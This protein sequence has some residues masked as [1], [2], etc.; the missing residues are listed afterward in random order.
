M[1]SSTI[2]AMRTIFL[3]DAHLTSS[4]EKNYRHVCLFLRELIGLTETLFIMGDLFDFWLGFPSRSFIAPHE[5]VLQVLDEL[6]RSGCRLV[7][8]EGN[9]DFHLGEVFSQRLGAEIHTGPAIMNVQGKRLYLCH[10]DQLNSE[11]YGYRLL[12]TMLHNRA[13]NSLVR[14]FPPAI[15]LQIRKRLQKTSRKGYAAKGARWNYTEIIR[16]QGR[17][18][19]SHGIDGL[20]TGHFHLP[21]CEKLDDSEFTILSLG[22]W[23]EKYTYGEMIAGELYLKKYHPIC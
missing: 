21:L 1:S 19:N 7:Y 6:T 5:P 4:D 3:A 2:Y 9:H 10:G 20:V 8:F 22:D 15:A 12:R 13:V 17:T 14:V 16:K 11:D 23:M 18:L